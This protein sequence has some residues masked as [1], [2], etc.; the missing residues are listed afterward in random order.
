MRN[1]KFS[2]TCRPNFAK[3]SCE[4]SAT[5]LPQKFEKHNNE[6]CKSLGDYHVSK[7]K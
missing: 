5:H 1:P 4:W 6:V 7:D 3:S 2:L